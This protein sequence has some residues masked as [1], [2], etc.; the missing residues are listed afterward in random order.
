M[1]KELERS[2]ESKKKYSKSEEKKSLDRVENAETNEIH[3]SDEKEKI[4]AVKQDLSQIK[5][6]LETEEETEIKEAVEKEDIEES[7]AEK[8]V[9]IEAEAYKTIILYASRY[10]NKSIPKEDW[11]EIYGVLIGHTDEEIVYVERAEALTYGHATDVQLN[12]RHLAFIAEIEDELYETGKNQFI[13]GWFHS[14]PGLGLFYSYVDL[15]NHI[16]FQGKNPDAIGLVFDNTLLGK[17]K[18]EKVEGTNHKITKY[19]TGFEIYRMNDVNM[20]VN[21]PEFDENYHEVDYIVKGLNKFFFA[22][23]LNELSSL[24]SEGRPLQ[25]A[26]REDVS[27][28]SNYQGNTLSNKENIEIPSS[29]AQ[30]N[31]QSDLNEYNEFQLQDIPM[32]EDITFDGDEL[33]YGAQNKQMRQTSFKE[34]KAEQ[35]IYEG[36]QAFDNNDV[37]QGVEKYREGIK[38][39]EEIGRYD[40]V[41]ELLK[42]V[43]EECISTDHI[44]LADEFVE[45]LLKIADQQNNLFY[46]AESHYL[47]GYLLL[48]QKKTE[49]VRGAL[50]KIRDAAVIFNDIKDYVGAAICFHKI[51][52]IFHTR[53]EKYEMG[54]IF[55]SEA[56]VNYNEAILKSHPLRKTMWSRKEILIH[57]IL[58]LKETTEELLPKIKNMEIQQKVI[59]DLK[60]IQYN[61]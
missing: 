56:I 34:E 7:R 32:N 58:D 6:E 23:M 30:T 38:K 49:N 19:E 54:A 27:L 11:K 22:N 14:H 55:Y 4:E 35:L 60:S 47:L 26:Y 2:N 16:G 28:E 24:V 31:K 9:V 33:F 53:L 48:K 45:K 57:K 61:F 40:R 3:T 51:G 46:K 36:N 17:K 41:L 44:I 10:A 52:A 37:F 39:L 59:N 20:D 1:S 43:T 13:V 8:A 25:S 5:E 18:L 21:K 29:P 12:D 42:D 50:N 15:I